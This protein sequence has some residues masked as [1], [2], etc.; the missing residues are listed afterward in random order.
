[1]AVD[2]WGVSYAAERIALQLVQG[3]LDNYPMDKGVAERRLQQHIMA[4]D[5]T[6][7]ELERLGYSQQY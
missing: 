3:L 4:G 7:E 1:M 5:I 6:R 2:Q